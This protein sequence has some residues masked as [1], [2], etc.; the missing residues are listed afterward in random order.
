MLKQHH[1]LLRIINVTCSLKTITFLSRRRA[2][3]VEN[4]ILMLEKYSKSL[5]EIVEDRTTSLR[6][7][8][9]K[10]EALLE[11]MLPK[12]VANQLMQGREV[13]F[14]DVSLNVSRLFNVHDSH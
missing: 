8:K 2:N 11:R 14:F 6:E 1:L 13:C 3:L 10:V 4:M 7:E 5:E 9:H 12:S